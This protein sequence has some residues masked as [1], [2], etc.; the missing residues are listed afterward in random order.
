MLIPTFSMPARTVS[1]NWRRTLIKSSRGGPISRLIR[2]GISGKDRDEKDGPPYSH[3]VQVGDPILRSQCEPVDPDRIRSQ[4]IQ[5]LIQN[6]VHVLE[7]YDSVGLS[8]PQIGINLQIIAMQMTKSQLRCW[9][10]AVIK[11]K[12]MEEIPLKILINPSMKIL[13]NKQ[14]FLLVRVVKHRLV[15]PCSTM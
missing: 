4:E 9:P 1:L 12:Q 8:A 5:Q 14:V 7:K 15:L 13:N 10:D 6:L 11:E 3:I 2:N